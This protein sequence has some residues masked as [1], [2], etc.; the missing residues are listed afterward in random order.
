MTQS[1]R[2]GVR[3]DADERL[4]VA[5]DGALEHLDVVLLEEGHVLGLVLLVAQ[6]PAR[7]ESVTIG[8]DPRPATAA[9][10]ART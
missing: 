2:H 3:V 7:P 1:V 10:T 4:L 8:E 9:R 5:V 6:I